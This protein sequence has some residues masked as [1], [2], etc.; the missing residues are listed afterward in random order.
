MKH[1]KHCGEEVQESAK[2]CN[3][4]GKNLEDD[5]QSVKEQTTDAD[6]DKNATV[7]QANSTEKEEPK[8]ESI[9]PTPEKEVTPTKKK[10]NSKGLK[11]GLIAGAVMFILLIGTYFVGKSITSPSKLLKNFETAI[12]EKDVETLSCMLKVNHKELEVTDEF[13]EAFI[14]LYESKPSELTYLMNYLKSQ[15]NTDYVPPVG[16]Y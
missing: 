15:V 11:F 16:M 1:C 3:H 10:K 13:I 14:Q 5:P 8:E 4:C 6:I 7:D 2:F 12:E 9:T